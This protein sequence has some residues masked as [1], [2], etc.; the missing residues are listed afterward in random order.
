MGN[1]KIGRTQESEEPTVSTPL[2][3]TAVGSDGP[4]DKRGPDF[5]GRT[6][7]ATSPPPSAGNMK[8]H[9]DA[10]TKNRSSRCTRK[11]VNDEAGHLAS[12]PD[13]KEN[14]VLPFRGT[15]L[16]HKSAPETM[17]RK[18]AVDGERHAAC[19]RTERS[20]SPTNERTTSASDNKTTMSRS[21]VSYEATRVGG[22]GWADLQ[23]AGEYAGR[24]AASKNANRR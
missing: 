23:D 21:R 13:H 12:C 17:Q 9:K 5:S 1:G 20:A 24:F 7:V 6:G 18:D 19:G 4:P 11:G 10:A 15:A 8:G 3:G 22:K 2:G 14:G 16:G